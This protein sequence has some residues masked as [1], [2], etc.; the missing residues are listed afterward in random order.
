LSD[1]YPI[2][3]GLK[4]GDTLSP[5]LFN[6]V[7]DNSIGKIKEKREELELNST[8]QRLACVYDVDLLSENINNVMRNKGTQLDAIWEVGLDATG[9]QTEYEFMC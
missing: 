4:E 3:N 6:L 9:E 7:L 8:R 2:Q 1:A 5:L